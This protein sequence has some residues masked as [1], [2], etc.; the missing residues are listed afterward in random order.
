MTKDEL[1]FK[2]I[3]AISLGC[4]KN[5]V[6]LE[7]MLFLL[8]EYG[9]EL[10]PDVVDADIVIVN[11]CAFIQ[12]ARE[13]AIENIIEMESLK[14]SGMIEK[15]IVTGCLPSK[16]TEQIKQLFPEVDAVI[17]YQNNNTIVNTIEELYSVEKSKCFV[18]YDRILTT[19]SGCAYLK[20]AD[21][22][23][24]A[25]AYCT[26]PRIRGPYKSEKIQNIVDEA[27]LLA[28]KG[29]KE[30]IIVAQDTTRYGIDLYGKRMLIELLEKLAKIKE[31]MWIRLHYAY[32]EMISS[33]LL[34]FID[35]EEKMCKYLDIPMQHIDDN[36]LALMRRRHNELSTRALVKEIKNYHPDI[37]IRSTFIIGHPGETRKAF[38]KLLKFLEAEKL[39]FVGFFPYS[40]EEGTVSYYMK[41]QKSEFV[42][43]HRLKIA[44]KTQSKVAFENAKQYLGKTFDVMID[45][46]DTTCGFFIGHTKFLSPSVD[47]GVKFVDNNSVVGDIVKVKFTDFD[48]NFFK[49][50]IE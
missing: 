33:E 34:N 5:R 19:S 7:K 23:N 35:N 16:H 32:P 37:K 44:Q 14:K 4:D 49:G 41:G 27:K 28:K 24:N 11:T 30:L 43:R 25:C 22:C 2:K 15:I 17:K 20:I 9:F 3:S 38:K 47:F 13:E 31:I 48:G 8:K 10:V 42:K 21:G 39:D 12:S 50:E 6:D 40:R 26:I 45:D 36:V 1:K 29:V 46:F 18:S